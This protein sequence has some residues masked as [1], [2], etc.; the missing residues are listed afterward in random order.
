MRLAGKVA[1]VTGGAQGIGAAYAT[2]LAQA[3]AA[4]AIG[5]VRAEGAEATARAIEAAGGRA[6]GAYADVTR[7]ESMRVLAARTAETYGGIDILV[8]NAAIYYGL[9]HHPLLRVPLEYWNRIMEVN[10]TGVLVAT[11][12]VVP[13]LQQRGKG[14]I[15]NQASIA[16]YTAGHYYNISKLGVIGLTIALARELGS[17][18][19]QVNAIAPGMINTEATLL[20]TTEEGRAAAIQRRALKRMGTPEDLTGTLV[21]LASDDSDWMTGQTIVIDG[22]FINRL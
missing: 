21:F 17:A 11:R 19:I 8:N 2:A 9:E 12:A 1:I 22:G 7:E 15:I 3:G 13:Y 4:V 14:K 18:N 10:V 16:A 5:D 20:Q 6:F